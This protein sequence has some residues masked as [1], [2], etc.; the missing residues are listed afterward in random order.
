MKTTLGIGWRPEIALAIERRTDIE[1]VEILF[2]NIANRRIPAPLWQLR[3][4]GVTI[5]PHAVSMSLGGAERPNI[6]RIKELNKLA[7][8][9]G[10][11]FV[12]EHIAFVRAGGKESGHLL[13]VPRTKASLNVLIEN[14]LIAKEHLTVPLALENIATLCDW[15]SSTLDEAEFLCQLLEK[16]ESWLLLDISNLYANS[17]NHHFDPIVFLNKL[18]LERIAYVHT[19]GG[20]LNKGIYHDTHAHSIVDGV[21][22][23]LAELLKMFNPPRVML[24]R[25]DNF[26]VETMLNAELDTIADIISVS[27]GTGQDTVN[28]F[29]RLVS[30]KP[31]AGKEN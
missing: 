5:V 24:E 26:P 30:G 28:K 23:L 10:A 18:P 27:R 21:H 3:E 6:K 4:R 2:E 9:L 11:P 13:P 12:S 7:V 16:T 25:D 19:A 31:A 8:T 14:I 17:V 22:S 29:D 15:K 20:V 1:F